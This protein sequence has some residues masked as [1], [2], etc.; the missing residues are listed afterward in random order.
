MIRPISAG[1]LC[2]VIDGVWKQ[3]SPNIGKHVTVL[4]RMGEHTKLGNIWL[5]EGKD[6]VLME[7]LGGANHKTAE[8][9]QSWLR[10]IEPD[11][12]PPKVIERELERTD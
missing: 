1:D 5:C 3:K 11:P 7:D 8:F 6:L 12:L 4:K 2:E 10:R 9:A